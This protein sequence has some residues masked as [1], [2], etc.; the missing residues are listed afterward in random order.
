MR[1]QLIIVLG[2][3]AATGLTLVVAWGIWSDKD[4]N[5]WSAWGQWVGGV[6]SIAAAWVALWLAWHGW[7]R[8][9][10]DRRDVDAQQAR[11]VMAQWREREKPVMQVTNHSFM[12]IHEIA[13]EG[14]TAPSAQPEVSWRCDDGFWGTVQVETLSPSA[15]DDLP[16]SYRFVSHD[17]SSPTRLGRVH[18]VISYT[19]A[20]GRRWQRV[21]NQEPY[22]VPRGPVYPE[23][24]E[25]L[26]FDDVPIR[27]GQALQIRLRLKWAKLQRP[28]RRWASPRTRK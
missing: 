21:G 15:T 26:S 18:A 5:W 12:P 14:I 1:K 7:Q 2:T 23:G 4:A 11:L 20:A 28:F 8:A 16:V 10:D 17:G 19:D 9:D 13:V 27:W 22:R 24:E 3:A 25:P 6:G